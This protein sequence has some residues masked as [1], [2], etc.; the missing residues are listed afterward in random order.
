MLE[1]QNAE[2]IFDKFNFSRR[3]FKVNFKEFIHCKNKTII[4]FKL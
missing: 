1:Y 4:I 2:F 3:K